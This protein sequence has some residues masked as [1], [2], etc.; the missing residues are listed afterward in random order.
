MVQ[1]FLAFLTF[2]YIRLV[3][4]TSIIIE[5]NTHN[6]EYYWNNNKPF[7]L[8]FWHSQL[9]MISFCWKSNSKINILASGHSDGRFGAIVGNYFKLNNI[10]TSSVK[11]SM[12]LNYQNNSS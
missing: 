7:I 2:L 9:M 1:H 4:T 3:S 6:P 8:A 5:K 10:Q 12:S 11:K